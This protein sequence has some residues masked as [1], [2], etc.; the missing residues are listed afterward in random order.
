M[1][2]LT[3]PLKAT[4]MIVLAAGST[5]AGAAED[6]SRAQ[7]N[8]YVVAPLVSNLSGRATVQDPVARRTEGNAPGI[9][10]GNI[11]PAH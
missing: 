4:A 10:Q 6:D 1:C 9:L 2:Q 5:I 8:A 7:R 11:V 3:R